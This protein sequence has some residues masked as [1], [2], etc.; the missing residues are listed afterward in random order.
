M[1]VFNGLK[2]LFQRLVSLVLGIGVLIGVVLGYGSAVQAS[3]NT[4]SAA[5][6]AD[7]ANIS[8]RK[9]EAPHYP[10]WYS[11]QRSLESLMDDADVTRTRSDA[12]VR[13]N[14]QNNAQ[15]EEQNNF[16]ER[17]KQGLEKVA[18][19]VQNKLGLNSADDPRDIEYRDT[20]NWYRNME[21]GDNGINVDGGRLIER[22]QQKLKDAAGNVRDTFSNNSSD[23]ARYRANEYQVKSYGETS[24]ENEAAWTYRDK[25]NR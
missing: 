8:Q 18:G 16:F 7:A 10:N 9:E 13:A 24:P 21:S 22:S 23:N 5:S 6:G 14:S 2:P 20:P 17:S 15:V 3:P 11:D 19:D 1:K 25:N 12:N 4:T